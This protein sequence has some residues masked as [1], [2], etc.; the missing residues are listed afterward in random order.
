MVLAVVTSA[1]KVA[2]QLRL[3]MLREIIE[4]IRIGMLLR[5][6]HWSHSIVKMY[7]VQY[8]TVQA[9]SGRCRNVNRYIV[10]HACADHYSCCFLRLLAWFWDSMGAWYSKKSFV[11]LYTHTLTRLHNLCSLGFVDLT[12][13]CYYVFF[14]FSSGTFLNKVINML[15]FVQLTLVAWIRVKSWSFSDVILEWG[16]RETVDR[17]EHLV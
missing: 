11:N 13:Y 14:G 2:H 5:W 15:C 16:S 9:T 17:W 4:L 12:C 6:Q 8:N 1:L 3:A 7:S 10:R